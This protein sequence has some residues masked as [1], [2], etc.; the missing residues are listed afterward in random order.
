MLMS[1]NDVSTT[2]KKLMAFSR[3]FSLKTD[4]YRVVWAAVLDPSLCQNLLSLGRYVG[5]DVQGKNDL[6]AFK[7]L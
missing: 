6:L 1:Y 3:Q 7:F 4:L 2:E 5:P